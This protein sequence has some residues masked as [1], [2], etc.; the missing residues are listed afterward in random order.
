VRATLDVRDRVIDAI[1]RLGGPPARRRPIV[2]D[3]IAQLARMRG[4]R[5]AA[6][7]VNHLSLA[8]QSLDVIEGELQ[9]CRVSLERVTGRAVEEFA[10][11]Y[12]AASRVSADVVRSRFRWG[13]SCDEGPIGASFD[14][15]RVGR[16]EVRNWTASQ[17]LERLDR[18]CAA[19]AR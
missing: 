1:A 6:H 2:A 8:E 17:L 18:V 13:L 7:T 14:A 19:S 3:E 12:G 11:P 15:A 16:V 9:G 4:A 10:Y 5:V